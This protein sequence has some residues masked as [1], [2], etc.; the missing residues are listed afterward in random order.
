M[1][2]GSQE[3]MLLELNLHLIFFKL[4]MYILLETIEVW[5]IE[6]AEVPNTLLLNLGQILSENDIL[7]IG[8]YGLSEESKK[9]IKSMECHDLPFERPYFE[10]F[11]LNRDDYPEG[12]AWNVLASKRNLETLAVLAS[13]DTD[14]EPTEIGFDHLLAYRSGSP[15]LPLFNYHDSFNGGDMFI[16]G[17]YPENVITNFCKII[18]ST[19]K[20]VRNP[21]INE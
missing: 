3:K 12:Q 13:F 9:I 8:S 15:L 11:D 5:L 21:E 17:L 16:S 20:H 10:T 19:Y 18:G 7:V 14:R 1:L 6:D 2:A 4:R